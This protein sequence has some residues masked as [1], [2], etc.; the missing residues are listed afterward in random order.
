MVLDK[1]YIHKSPLWINILLA[2]FVTWIS[3]AV[4]LHFYVHRHLSFHIVVPIAQLLSAILSIYVSILLLRFFKTN[5]DFTLS[6]L[7]IVICIEVLYFYEAL[8]L[9]LNKKYGYKTVFKKENHSK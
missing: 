6:V 4:F 1:A 9:W 2:V 7:A 8:A 5:I 3:F